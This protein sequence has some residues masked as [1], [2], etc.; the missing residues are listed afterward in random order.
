LRSEEQHK[1]QTQEE[2]IRQQGTLAGQPTQAIP[3]ITFHQEAQLE[4]NETQRL[5][6]SGSYAEDIS[7]WPTNTLGEM[8]A[9]TE[10]IESV[11]IHADID[12][13]EEQPTEHLSVSPIFPISDITTQ[14][15]RRLLP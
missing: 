6:I 15:T 13:I 5:P 10:R 2:R 14:P 3:N 12:S 11:S 7:Q 1:A 4:N 9:V 8:E